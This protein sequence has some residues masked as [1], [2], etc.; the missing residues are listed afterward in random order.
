MSSGLRSAK[1]VA[2]SF[3]ETLRS[4]QKVNEKGQLAKRSVGKVTANIGQAFQV[5]PHSSR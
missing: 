1:E 3:G 4:P 2:T 5:S